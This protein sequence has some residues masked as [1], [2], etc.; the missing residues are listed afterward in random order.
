MVV[1]TSC[2]AVIL[3][4]RKDQWVQQA[5]LANDAVFYGPITGV[6]ARA[7]GV[8]FSG[9][10]QPFIYFVGWGSSSKPIVSMRCN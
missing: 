10:N 9:K 8:Y 7:E 4:I 3:L 1:G 2:G 5:I 6:L